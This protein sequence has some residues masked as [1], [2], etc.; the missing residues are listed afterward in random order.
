MNLHLLGKQEKSSSQFRNHV[1]IL[2]GRLA[3]L[4]AVPSLWLCQ[5]LRQLLNILG[6]QMAQKEV[7]KGAAE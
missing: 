2:A 3:L 4:V 7:Q 5:Q 6:F 1:V